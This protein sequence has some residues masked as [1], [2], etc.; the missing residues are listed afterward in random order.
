MDCSSP[1]SSISDSSV[2]STEP[3]R[4]CRGSASRDDA[5][6]AGVDEPDQLGR[7]LAGSARRPNTDVIDGPSYVKG[8]FAAPL[9]L[10]RQA[11]VRAARSGR[12]ISVGP[13]R[14]LRVRPQRRR[15]LEQRRRDLPQPLDALGGR[16]QRAV[17]GHG[18]VDQPLVG[19]EHVLVL[20]ASRRARTACSPSRAACPAR[21]ACR[22][23]TARA[24]ACRRGRRSGGPGPA[25][26]D[27]GVGR[28]H[29]LG[30]LAEG[31]ADHARALGHA[32]AGP[33]EERDARPSA[34]CRRC[35]RAATNV[36]TSESGAT[37]CSSR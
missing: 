27:A 22:R 8:V 5:D 13:P 17:A 6:R 2:A 15:M 33:Q 36:S 31:D 28:E 24:A 12:P 16:E 14:A 11:P 20:P 9:A 35:T 4:S 30:R 7:H 10:E 23:T 26:A 32:L 37:P 29:R 19:L 21:A 25:R 34:S 3:P 18:V 1:S